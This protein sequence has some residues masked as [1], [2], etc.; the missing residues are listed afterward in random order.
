IIIVD[1][2]NLVDPPLR[3]RAMRAGIRYIYLKKPPGQQGLTRSRN[4]GVNHATSDLIFFLDDDVALFPDFMERSIAIYQALP[5]VSGM[6]GGEVLTKKNSPLAKLWFFYDVMF[7]MTGFKKGYFLPSC[8]STNMGNPVLKTRLAPVEFLGGASFSFRRNVFQ[9]Y[10]FSEE[11]QGYGLGEDKDFSYRVSQNHILVSTPD[12][13]LHHYESPVMRYQKY[14]KA[15]AK[16]MS[17]YGFLTRCNVKKRFSG[18]WFCYAM[19]GYLL[20]R[21]LIM[22]VSFD[23]S[24]VQRVRGILA[25]FKEILAL[26]K[27]GKDE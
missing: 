14:Q 25:G 1:D 15:K 18:F 8:F 10:R 13:R 16:V 23:T 24:E 20:K 3:S 11:F 19:A 26:R 9:S 27:A 21:S 12:A 22:A 17:K 7:C 5:Q 2:G 6:G 4:L